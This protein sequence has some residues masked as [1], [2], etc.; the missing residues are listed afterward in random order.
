[1][2]DILQIIENN[3][4]KSDFTYYKPI[5]IDEI[6]FEAELRKSCE[7]NACGK[8]GGSY[9][10]PPHVG[11]INDCIAKVK[12]YSKGFIFQYVGQ[13][14]DSYDFEGMMENQDVFTEKVRKFRTEIKDIDCLVLGAGPCTLC[15]ECAYKTGKPCVSKN[16]MIS[17]VEAHGMFV[18]PTLLNVGLH[19]NNGIDTVSY[20][21]IVMIK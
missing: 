21:G 10:C 15:K 19:Y 8:F 20:V 5:T 9:S 6:V 13:L 12:K 1:M 14:E 11:E 17:S 3:V 16:L 2:N 7:M 18:N 4:A